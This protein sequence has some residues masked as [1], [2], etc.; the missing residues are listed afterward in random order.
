MHDHEY[1]DGDACEHGEYI[2]DC[3]EC[4][5]QLFDTEEYERKEPNGNCN[6][7]F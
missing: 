3:E 6:W 2:W 1:P 5:P 7:N 4:N